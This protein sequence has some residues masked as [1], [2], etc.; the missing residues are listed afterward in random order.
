MTASSES[1]GPSSLDAHLS[2]TL[3]A[4]HLKPAEPTP[5][6][7]L[8]ALTR[9]AHKYQIGSILA[10]TTRRL[11][12]VF[13]DSLDVWQ[14]R[15][16]KSTELVTMEPSNTIEALNLFRLI[17]RTDLLATALYMCAQLDIKVLLRGVL[18]ADGSSLET[19]SVHDIEVCLRTKQEFKTRDARMAE[20]LTSLPVTCS[21]TTRK[22]CQAQQSNLHRRTYQEYYFEASTDPLGTHLAH[23]MDGYQQAGLLCGGCVSFRKDHLRYMQGSLWNSFPLLAAATPLEPNFA[24]PGSFLHSVPSDAAKSTRGFKE[25]SDIWFDDGS[26]IIVADH[27]GFRVHRG[28]LSR[29]SEVFRGLFGIPQSQCGSSL[30]TAPESFGGCPVVHVPD[31]AYDIKQLLLAVYEVSSTCH[32]RS[33]YVRHHS[34]LFL[35]T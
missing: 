29:Q 17:E 20:T 26:I 8:S 10:E 25:D 21:E 31:T 14:Q 33:C 7:V 24:K 16:G 6:P 27:N 35:A 11:K 19:L 15:Q 5:F 28:S 9:M 23:R 3:C 13:T 2:L 1:F 22:Q 18:R 4:S 32:I 12:S 34:S 30:D